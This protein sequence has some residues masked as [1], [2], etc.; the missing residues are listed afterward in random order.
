MELRELGRHW[1]KFGKTDPL[2]AVLS[3]PGKR[4]GR[5][6]KD[7]F[8]E[9]GRVEIERILERVDKAAA[10]AGRQV[11]RGR[12]LDFG[13]GVGR[14]T[15][16]LGG[17]FDRCDGVD[18]APSMVELAREWNAH[19]DRCTY[20]V[21]D[22]DDLSL[23]PDGTFDFVYTAHVLQHMEPRF[24]R[25]YVDEFFRLLAPGGMALFEMVTEPVVGATEALP[26]D[27]FRAELTVDAVPEILQPGE[28][29]LVD[30]RV[31]NAGPATFPATGRE[32]WYQVSVGNHWLDAGGTQ[33]VVD[34]GRA[35]LPEDVAPGASVQ[36]ELEVTAPD[37]RG[38][39]RLE[40]DCVQEGVAWFADRGSTTSTTRVKVRRR[41]T[42]SELLRRPAQSGPDG[43]DAGGPV[44]EMHGV[45]EDEVR[46]WV[47]AAG[48]EVLAVID[49]D[50]ISESRSYDWQRRGFLVAR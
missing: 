31:R 28:H 25:R 13:C 9:S 17:A 39:Y 21:N 41:R 45:T 50:E 49:W 5:W 40:V 18:I 46:T 19:G 3:A 2:W 1:E 47:R 30:V 36:L 32:G 22:R 11:T 23:F 29:A 42:L 15:Q 8:F 6:D 14:L 43:G 27:A 20:H 4:H 33:V 35:A 37:A 24:S 10:A 7:A 26:D 34:D 12:A 16:A 44:M 48:G 38:A